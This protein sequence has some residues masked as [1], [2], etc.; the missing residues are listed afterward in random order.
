MDYTESE[1][2]LESKPE[3]ESHKSDFGTHAAKPHPLLS[4]IYIQAQNPPVDRTSII[5]A[6]TKWIP[7][8]TIPTL[9]VFGSDTLQKFADE[10]SW[11]EVKAPLVLSTPLQIGQAE[12]AKELLKGQITGIF[13][14]C[15][16]AY[17]HECHKALGYAKDQGADSVISIGGESTIGLQKAISIRTGL[18]HICIPTAYTISEMAPILSE[19]ANRSKKTQSEPRILP[20]TVIYNVELTM[21]LPVPIS[22]TSGVNAIAT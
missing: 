3:S 9:S 18:P 10:I 4:E 19:T 15:D 5:I 12:K 14:G 20:D 8:S 21:T 11:P 13:S 1:P 7:S 17:S 6:N 22:A 2:V 16:Y